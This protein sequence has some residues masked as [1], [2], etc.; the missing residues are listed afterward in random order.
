MAKSQKKTAAANPEIAGYEFQRT[1]LLD[2]ALTHPSLSGS[3]NY[4][5]FEFLGDRVLGLVI[6][7][8]LLE[9]YPKEAEGELNRRF[10]ALVRRE[11]LAELSVKLG[12]AE[13]LQVTPGAEAEGTK[14]KEAIQADVC[15]SVIGAL[16]L[17]GGFSAADSFI[18][19][20]WKPLIGVGVAVHKDN[21]T[22]LQ[23]WC[24][25]RAVT[26]PRYIEIE[27]S[28]P[29]HDPIFVIEAVVGGVGDDPVTA[30]ASGPAKRLAEQMAAES[31]Y[32]KLTGEK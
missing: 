14:T 26:L 23:E 30:R 9:E 32:K 12:I 27:R 7:T 20:H 18:R 13:R 8:W 6:A 1:S 31:L 4:Q 22:L 5:R 2:E 29:D 3:H 15:E 11:T 28:G 25:A 19:K 24:Q 17:D 16:Y 21:K 10:T